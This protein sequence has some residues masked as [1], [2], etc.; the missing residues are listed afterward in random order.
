V[1]AW[2]GAVSAQHGDLGTEHQ[3]LDVRGCI[4]ASEQRHLAQHVGEHQVR[5]ADG[6]QQAIMLRGLRPG[7]AS[8]AGREGA[9]ERP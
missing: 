7:T 3:D 2:G 8:S 1:V 4:G 9:D 6:P 5:E